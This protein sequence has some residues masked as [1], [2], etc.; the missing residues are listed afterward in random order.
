MLPLCPASSF[1]PCPNGHQTPSNIDKYRLTY[2][3]CNVQIFIH[4]LQNVLQLVNK[5]LYKAFSV[6]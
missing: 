2:T 4:E 3:K 1:V 5:N 6:L